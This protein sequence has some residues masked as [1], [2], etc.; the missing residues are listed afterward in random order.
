MGSTRPRSAGRTVP[1]DLLNRWSWQP[2]SGSTGG[3]TGVCMV[4]S[5]ISH[6]LNSRRS[7]ITSATPPT[8]RDSTP[9]SLQKTQGDSLRAWEEMVSLVDKMPRTIRESVMVREQLGLALNRLGRADEADS[10]LQIG[11]AH[12]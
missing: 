3:T 12:V 11:R 6:R 9:P 4:P 2:R 10:V 8:R 1:G 5:A 7:T